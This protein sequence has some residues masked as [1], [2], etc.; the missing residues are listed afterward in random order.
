MTAPRGCVALVV[1]LFIGF[2]A[3]AAT[4]GTPPPGATAR[5]NDG[6]YSYSQ[7]HSGT[8]SHHGGVAVWLTSSTSTSTTSSTPPKTGTVDVGKTILLASRTKTSGCKL[9][10]LPDRRC[11]PGAYYSGGPR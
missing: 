10:P 1:A 5:C 7:H 2:F 3:S 6:T 9:G 8:C 11:S 4:G